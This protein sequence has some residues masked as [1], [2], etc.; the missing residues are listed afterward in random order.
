MIESLG[1]DIRHAVRVLVAAPAFTL[2]AIVVIALGVGANTAVFSVVNAVILRPLPFPDAERI[3]RVWHVPPP[4]LFPGEKTFPVSAANYIDW[5]EKNHVFDEMAAYGGSPYTLTGRGEAESV[6][7]LRVTAGFFRVFGIQPALGRSFSPD[8][9]RAGRDG[10]VILGDAFWRT[11]FGGDAGIVGQTIALNGLPRVVVGIL[12]RGITFPL[13][14]QVWVPMGWTDEQRAVRGNHNRVVIARL[15]SGVQVAQAQAEMDAISRDLAQAYPGD[16]ANWGAVVIP[17]QEDIVGGVRT[18]LLILL[19]AVALVLLIACANL[20]NL[21]L[22]KTLARRREIAVRL[23]LGAARARIIQQILCETVLLSLA[24][25]LAGLLL[26]RFG[27]TSLLLLIANRLPRA[28]EI[29]LDDRVLAFTLVLAIVTGL[30][31]GLVPAWRLTRTNV[32]D[33]LKQGLGRAGTDSGEHRTRSVL[34]VSEVALAI[35]LLVGAGLLTRSLWQLYALDPGIDPRHVLTMTVS[36]PQM[37][38]PTPAEQSRF[39]ERALQ[40]IRTLPGVAAAA[41]IDTLPLTGGGSIQPIAVPGAPP[42]PISEQPEVEVRHIT[43][44]YLRTLGMRLIAGRDITDSDTADR[45]AVVLVSESMARQFWPHE[46]AVGK[47]LTMSFF[48]VL[49][50]VVG[51]VA[52]VKLN[53]LEVAAPVSTLYAPLAQMPSPFMALAVRTTVPPESV[54]AAVTN[55]IH[56]VDREQPVVN[57]KSMEA[58]VGDSLAPARFNMLLLGSFAALALALAAIGIYSVLAYAVSQ[59]V[60]EIGIRMA[61]GAPIGGLLRLVL[62][63]GMKPTLIGIAIGIAGAAAL[64]RLLTTLIFGVG[65]HDML[66]FASVSLLVVIVGAIASLLPAYRATRVDPLLALRAE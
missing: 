20:A 18:G 61:L 10:V 6:R 60:K 29:N 65:T 48:P 56:Q 52:D 13:T 59:R 2:A 3:M 12:P 25:G 11:R 22:A 50:E 66:T 43:P 19:G 36:L 63:Q 4:L 1:R 32:N 33:A 62:I 51:V 14:A 8:E 46:S 41:G 44:G 9:D 47:Q 42:R 57:V 23:A 15:K 40:D 30:A 21:L 45:G 49:R 5:R 31:A 39:Y 54:A 17:L 28:A 58:V 64:G 38:Y 35:V 55:A 26:A 7:G 27:L 53:G 24:G 37:K 34:V 16:N